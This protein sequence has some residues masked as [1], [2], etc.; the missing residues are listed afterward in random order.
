MANIS[1]LS[2][3]EQRQRESRLWIDRVGD[4]VEGHMGNMDVYTVRRGVLF[5]ARGVKGIFKERGDGDKGE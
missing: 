5:Q 3:L 4:V 2:D 1:F